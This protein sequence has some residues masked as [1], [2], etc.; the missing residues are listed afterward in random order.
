MRT[1]GNFQ[2]N[3]VLRYIKNF[4]RSN[5]LKLHL[6]VN[7]FQMYTSLAYCRREQKKRK[8]G[9][10]LV[11]V[12]TWNDIDKQDVK[13]RMNNYEWNSDEVYWFL[14][15]LVL[16]TR[17]ECAHEI[18]VEHETVT[19]FDHKICIQL[20]L[21]FCSPTYLPVIIIQN[22]MAF[23]ITGKKKKEKKTDFCFLLFC[24]SFSVIRWRYR[25]EAI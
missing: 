25:T 20:S 12:Q 11:H 15:S 18:I 2:I 4:K 23:F 17:I 8:G 3:S 1:Q 5:F 16:V 21:E 14:F 6:P 22:M 13:N 10:N 19:V 9:G 7:R 24:P